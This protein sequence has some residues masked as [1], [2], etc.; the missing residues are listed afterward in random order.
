MRDADLDLGAAV[1]AQQAGARCAVRARQ[2]LDAPARE[3]DAGAVEALDHGLLGGPTAGQ[4]LFVARA[5]GQL[6]RGVDL[7]EEA[8]TG[9]LDGERDPI[10]RDR[11]DADALHD[12]ILAS[13][14]LP[15]RR[16]L[17][18]SP[19]AAPRHLPINGAELSP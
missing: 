19:S 8:E 9:P 3:A 16:R 17:V 15:L 14:E 10:H 18:N 11:V 1:V 7:V 13:G 5:V 6:G 2:H 12:T 4:A